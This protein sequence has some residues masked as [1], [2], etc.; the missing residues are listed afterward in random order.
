MDKKNSAQ[1]FLSAFRDF[2]RQSE[3]C[4]LRESV[5]T[6]TK[7]GILLLSLDCLWA[8]VLTGYK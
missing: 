3:D 1:L 2:W 4:D 8:Q 7:Q 5:N 6:E